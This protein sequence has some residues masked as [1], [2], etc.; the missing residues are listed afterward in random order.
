MREALRAAGYRLN[1]R[2]LTDLVLRYGNREG[3]LG[4]DD[5]IMCAIKLK[6]MIGIC[7]ELIYRQCYM[8]SSDLQRRLSSATQV[9]PDWPPSLWTNGSTK[10]FILKMLR[11]WQNSE[12]NIKALSA[13]LR[14]LPTVMSFFSIY[15]LRLSCAIHCYRNRES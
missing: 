3:T 12:K 1:R 4:F 6:I 7:Y 14:K 8:Y 11:T 9:T 2:V 5:F 15:C 10:L 13:S